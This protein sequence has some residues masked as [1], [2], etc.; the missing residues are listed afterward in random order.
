M[1]IDFKR[2][3]TNE[4]NA[5][6]IPKDAFRIIFSFIEPVFWHNIVVTCKEFY[7]YGIDFF[8]H[9]S[10]NNFVL[11]EVCK[12]GNYNLIKRLLESENKTIDPSYYRCDPCEDEDEYENDSSCDKYEF[13][14][15]PKSRFDEV[16]LLVSSNLLILFFF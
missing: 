8:D 16:R 7:Q 10:N 3:K 2:V 13:F 12:K 4:S 9:T 11:L 6:N 15:T 1:E 5:Y 14:H